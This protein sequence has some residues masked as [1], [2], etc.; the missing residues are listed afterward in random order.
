MEIS[1][2]VAFVVGLLSTIHCVGMCGGI[3]G[4]LSFA[5]PE[6]AR[7]RPVRLAS[8]L[9]AY[10][11]G[12]IASYAVGGALAG[13]LG[14]TVLQS[15]GSVGTANAL[16][17]IAGLLMVLAGLHLGG[18]LPAVARLERLGLPLWRHLEPHARRLVP[19]RTPWRAA[20]Y[21]ALWGW[22][23]CGLVYTMLG[24]AAAGASV[25][26]GAA[27]MAAFGLGTLPTLVVTGVFAGRLHS[28]RR[29][30]RLQRAGG[31][32]VALLG[33]LTIIYV[34]VGESLTESPVA[35]GSLR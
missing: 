17:G 12:R 6:G 18:W 28:L 5:L 7:Q 19:V 14:L 11:A 3:M 35:T 8:F 20:L 25:A 32:A 4:A 29:S 10:N 33:I 13:G 30:P 34:L 22:L 1:L 2:P 23:P 9:L 21:G 15:S 26:A 24:L 16:R 27:T 31:A